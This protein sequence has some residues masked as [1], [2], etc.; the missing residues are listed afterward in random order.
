MLHPES[1][2]SPQRIKISVAI[3]TWNRSRLLRRTLER[4]C[5]INVDDRFTWEL[6]LVNNN[7]TDDTQ[8]VID[9]FSDSLPIVSLFESVQGHSASRNCAIAAAS[10]DYIVWTDNDV[11]VG[12]DWLVSYCDAFTTEPDVAYFG[13]QIEPWFE[14]P[15]CPDWMEATWEKCKSVYAARDLGEQPVE[16]SE[17]RLPYGANFAIRTDVQRENLYDPTL[18]R[19]HSGMLGE[20][21]THVLKR[22]ARAGETGRW[23][24][25]AKVQHIIPADRATERYVRSYFVGQGQAN[26]M[27]GKQSRNWMGALRDAAFESLL[28]RIKRHRK[29]PDEWVSHMIGASISWGEFKMLS[30]KP[31]STPR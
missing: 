25:R 27:F 31:N 7:S 23:V 30:L 4:L 6:I 24:P 28:Y 17:H 13:G 29:A 15:G 11:L 8:Q 21:E 5:E 2:E 18:G 16:L 26:V 20:D 9:G 1:P 22:I 19:V 12:S 3:C 10:G 14:P